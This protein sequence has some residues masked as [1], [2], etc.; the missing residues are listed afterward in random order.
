MPKGRKVCPECNAAVPCRSKVCPGCGHEFIA[1]TPPPAHRASDILP[2]P[3]P[4]GPPPLLGPS[5]PPAADIEPPAKTTMMDPDGDPRG[6]LCVRHPEYGA[7]KPPQVACEGCWRAYLKEKFEERV[8]PFD[9]A[10]VAKAN[11]ERAITS[12]V[13]DLI[14]ARTKSEQTGGCYSAFLHTKDGTVLQIDVHLS[15]KQGEE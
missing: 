4:P 1:K 7:I 6:L 3:S 12:F 2:K 5:E 9:P 10:V 14:A 8:K 13:S 15:W 11:D